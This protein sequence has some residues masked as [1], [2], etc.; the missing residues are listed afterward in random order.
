VTAWETVFR[1]Q[2][3]LAADVDRVLVLGGAGAVGSL[4]TQLLKARTKA[5]VISTGSR[6]GS[7]DWCERM[8]AD[9]VLD[10]GADIA[11]QLST[12]GIPHVD[13]VLSTAKSADN[14]GW[15]ANVLRPFGHLSVVDGGPPLDVR[16]LAPKAAS[17]HMEMVFSGIICCPG[18]TVTDNFL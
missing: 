15:I 18:R 11:E 12:A 14:I 2:D 7:R 16:S 1:D 8:G 6:P 10:H 9:R 17:F 3:S 4:A 5:F 13:W